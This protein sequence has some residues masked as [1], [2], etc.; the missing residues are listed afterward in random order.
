M[1]GQHGDPP[2]RLPTLPPLSPTKRA[3]RR[4]RYGLHR[5]SSDA[6]QGG[7]K[8]H[9]L[10]AAVSARHQGRWLTCT[11]TGAT[12]PLARHACGLCTI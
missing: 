6:S 8:S 12:R 4:V 1:V 3:V 7:S 5:P 10:S 11:A 9:S 2:H